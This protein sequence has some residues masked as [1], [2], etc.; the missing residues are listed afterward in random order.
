MATLFSF[1]YHPYSVHNRVSVGGEEAG[2]ATR[3]EIDMQHE[4]CLAVVT[5]FSGSAILKIYVFVGTILGTRPD[6]E[7]CLRIW[8]TPSPT[9]CLGLVSH[10]PPQ[11]SRN[12]VLWV[13]KQR[14]V[15]SVHPGL[16]LPHLDIPQL[17][18]G[19]AG[20]MREAAVCMGFGKGSRRGKNFQ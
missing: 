1:V 7:I 9:L 13:W 14:H 5:R 19:H 12:S 16:V 17:L 6:Q 11:G 2:L 4:I 18:G 15:N 20:I 10:R 3:L 8:W